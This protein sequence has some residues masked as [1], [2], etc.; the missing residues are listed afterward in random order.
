MVVFAGVTCHNALMRPLASRFR[1]AALCLAGYGLVGLVLTIGVAWGIAAFLP[2]SQAFGLTPETSFPRAWQPAG[3]VAAR[4]FVV[5][6]LGRTNWQIYSSG[7][8]PDGWVTNVSQ[9]GFPVPALESV[10]I[11]DGRVRK[12]TSNPVMHG[13][14]IPGDWP[15][16]WMIENECYT[17]HLPLRPVW[18]GLAIDTVVWGAAAFMVARVVGGV[19]AFGR[20]RR[21]RCRVCAY[22][23]GGLGMCPGCGIEAGAAIA[24]S[25]GGP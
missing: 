20:Q 3:D 17:P 9:R 7:Q 5:R 23:L 1:S 25:D 15:K 6:R 19:R 11:Y 8:L 12:L 21:G 16:H 13:I 2:F 14:P 18:Y 4:G 22:E 24:G 10:A